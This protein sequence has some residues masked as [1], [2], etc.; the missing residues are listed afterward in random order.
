[1]TRYPGGKTNMSGRVKYESY[2][3]VLD[4]FRWLEDSPDGLRRL[5]IVADGLPSY[6]M[7]L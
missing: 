4:V 1:M 2:R 6:P 7:V 3:R 5:A